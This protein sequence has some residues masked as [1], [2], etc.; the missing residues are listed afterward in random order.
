M[1]ILR[2]FRVWGIILFVMMTVAIVALY[3]QNVYLAKKDYNRALSVNKPIIAQLPAPSSTSPGAVID[4]FVEYR[5]E[6]DRVRSERIDLLREVAK[7]GKSEDGA[8]LKLH[9]ALINITV[10]KQKELETENLIKA[11]G[12]T[13]AIVFLHDK[14]INVIVKTASLSKQEVLQIADII[15]RTTGIRPEDITISTKQ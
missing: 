10:E 12:F 11:K 7:S 1:R 6:R 9:D 8:R 15:S 14:S 2:H 3:L 4:F 5:V 13:D